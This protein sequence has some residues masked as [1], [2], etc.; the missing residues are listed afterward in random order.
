MNFDPVS[1]ISSLH[2]V[3]GN[4]FLLMSLQTKKKLNDASLDNKN[5]P[6]GKPELEVFSPFPSIEAFFKNISL[7]SRDLSI[8]GFT[9]VNCIVFCSKGIN[10]LRV[11]LYKSI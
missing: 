4:R 11:T 2:N 3:F 5:R 7:I 6:L 1:Y 9:V 10:L 8:Q